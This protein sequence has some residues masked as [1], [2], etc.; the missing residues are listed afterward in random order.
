MQVSI[1]KLGQWKQLTDFHSPVK[2]YWTF[3]PIQGQKCLNEGLISFYIGIL[4]SI[5]ELLVTIIPIHFIMGLNMPLNLRL[6][7]L[8]LLC[9]GFIAT[10]AGIVRVYF[11]YTTM[12]NFDETWASYPLWIAAA[13]EANLGLV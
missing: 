13:V 8:A 6:S 3:P 1:N 7:V 12:S 11:T 2:A 5:A 4:H 10:A 9:L